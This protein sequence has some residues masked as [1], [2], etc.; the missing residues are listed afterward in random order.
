MANREAIDLVGEK[1]LLKSVW[2]RN[3]G[4]WDK[5]LRHITKN[6]TKKETVKGQRGRGRQRTNYAG[7][8]NQRCES[9]LVHNSCI[10][11]IKKNREEN[12]LL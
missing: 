10:N 3:G 12:V 4:I 9:R 11:H 2:E 5:S 8:N 1:R 7:Q 6:S